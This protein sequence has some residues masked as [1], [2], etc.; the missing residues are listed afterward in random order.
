ML[1]AIGLAISFKEL[2]LK[3]VHALFSSLPG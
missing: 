1:P 3:I 2:L